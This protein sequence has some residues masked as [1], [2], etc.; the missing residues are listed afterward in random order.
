[1][2]LNIFKVFEFAIMIY[3][4][5]RNQIETFNKI[6]RTN[7]EFILFLNRNLNTVKYNY[8]LTELKIAGIV[9]VVKKI[10]YIIKFIFKLFIIIYT[11]YSAIIFISK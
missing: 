2:D 7:I 1:M 6:I 10:R 4:Y 9:W 8:Y 5:K 3:H 11:N